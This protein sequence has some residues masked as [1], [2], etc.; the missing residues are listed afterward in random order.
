MLTSYPS[1]ASPALLTALSEEY[2]DSINFS[3]GEIYRRIC[4][5]RTE[6]EQSLNNRFAEKRL[7]AR[8]TKSKR[9]DLKQFLKSP[10]AAGFDALRVI[11]GLWCGFRIGH[12]FLALRCDKVD[13][14][15]FSLLAIADICLGATALPGPYFS[16]LVGNIRT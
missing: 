14:K 9:R 11:P 15:S 12:K 4:Q 1:G 5:Y 8:L 2:S 6:A 16:S 13:I 3:D 10:L 7:W